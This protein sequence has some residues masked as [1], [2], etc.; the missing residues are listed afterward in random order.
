[1]NG[2]D[3]AIGGNGSTEICVRLEFSFKPVSKSVAQF[4]FF[5]RYAC[6]Y[7]SDSN[8]ADG[9]EMCYLRFLLNSKYVYDFA[10]SVV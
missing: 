5:L 10:A 9:P 8:R 3:V 1:V 2:G 4:Y 6:M 7:Q